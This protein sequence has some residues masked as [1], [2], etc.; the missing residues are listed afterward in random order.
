MRASAR[1]HFILRIALVVGL[2]AAS[3]V[4]IYRAQHT[5]TTSPPAGA[6][7]FELS[8]SATS[9]AANV[10]R[11]EATPTRGTSVQ[12][13]P[14]TP[15]P[16]TTTVPPLLR[17]PENSGIGR[18]VVY[19]KK[20][21]R[22]WLIN[23]QGVVDNTYRVSGNQAWD[24]PRLGTYSVYS[25]SRYTCGYAPVAD[26]LCWRYMVR[27]AY[28]REGGRIGFHEIPTNTRTGGPVQSLSQL[29]SA[30]SG[31]CVRQSTTDA[32]YMWEWADV[33]TPVVVVWD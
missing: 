4:A 12:A 22:V 11:V 10:V 21:M 13:L 6:S 28:G 1:Q 19:S 5:A 7:T 24:Q 32:H 16:T 23:A 18:R 14:T 25:R 33:G 2:A 20:R 27:F 15:I 30:L 9:S 29:G 8:S 26:H 3:A 31:G 17:V